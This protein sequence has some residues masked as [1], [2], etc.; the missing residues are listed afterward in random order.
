MEGYKENSIEE[1]E[2]KQKVIKL[3]YRQI[4]TLLNKKEINK[5]IKRIKKNDIKK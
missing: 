4:K 1:I 3:L 2:N 5:L